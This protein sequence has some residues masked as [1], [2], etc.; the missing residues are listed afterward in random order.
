MQNTN[1]MNDKKTS[2]IFD[3]MA[4]VKPAHVDDVNDDHGCH[5][6]VDAESPRGR[7]CLVY[8]CPKTRNLF[9]L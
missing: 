8:Y 9:L 7:L 3:F 6:V 5:L 1:D 2:E 4:G